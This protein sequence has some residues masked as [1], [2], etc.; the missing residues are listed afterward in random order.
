MKERVERGCS[1]VSTTLRHLR[2]SGG[3]VGEE[4]VEL[5]RCS[6]VRETERENDCDKR[7]NR[8]RKFA[9]YIFFIKVSHC[10][11]LE[12]VH[13]AD[14]NSTRKLIFVT[15][16]AYV[17]HAVYATKI[18]NTTYTYHVFCVVNI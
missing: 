15:R 17:D 5:P 16:G 6:D 12:V 7:E 1:F 14:E 3:D 4:L 11:F 2:C 13:F 8:K 9:S 18:V 10:P